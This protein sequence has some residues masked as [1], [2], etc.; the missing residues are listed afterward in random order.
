MS[1]SRCRRGAATLGALTML[2]V[3]A[4]VGSAAI[5]EVEI[6][7]A[8]AVAGDGGSPPL[9]LARFD[10]PGN[11]ADAEVDLAVDDGPG[12]GSEV[13]EK[14]N[15]DSL[16]RREGHDGFIARESLLFLGMDTPGKSP[17]FHIRL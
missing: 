12:R 14:G 17:L 1:G 4:A 16:R 2:C 8:A 9:H 7:A 3:A 15:D 10:L 11:L 6:S 5:I 13:L